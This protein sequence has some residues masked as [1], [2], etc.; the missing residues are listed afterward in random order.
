MSVGDWKKSQSFIIIQL[1]DLLI[2]YLD[3]LPLSLKDGVYDHY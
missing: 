1:K 2:L 3:A